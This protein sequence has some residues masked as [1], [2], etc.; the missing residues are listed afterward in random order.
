MQ[1]PFPC[2]LLKEPVR[3]STG[4]VNRDA[5]A[6]KIMMD[7]AVFHFGRKISRILR[8]RNSK[9]IV[10]VGTEGSFP[11]SSFHNCRRLAF[12]VHLEADGITRTCA[13]SR[14][15]C[16]TPKTDLP[17][18]PFMPLQRKR[19]IKFAT[20]HALLLLLKLLLLILPCVLK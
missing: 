20:P 8:V 10:G 6:I 2:G 15:P 1:D 14:G 4:F 13:C 11:F 5:C 12:K 18:L 16:S 17:T 9:G 19:F 3:Q 7:D